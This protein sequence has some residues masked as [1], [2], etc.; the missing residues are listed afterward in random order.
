MY[1][2]QFSPKTTSNKKKWLSYFGDPH[3]ASDYEIFPVIVC[4]K[5]PKLSTPGV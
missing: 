5:E 3:L 4:V 1:F 2:A